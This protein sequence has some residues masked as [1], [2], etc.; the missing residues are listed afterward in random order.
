MAI[1][2]RDAERERLARFVV[3]PSPAMFLV[4]G[5]PGIGKTT[6][7][8]SGAALAERSG[9]RVLALRPGEAE[10]PLAFAGLAGLL[11]DPLLNAT[12]PAIPEPRRRALDAALLR[13]GSPGRG[14]DADPGT[15]GLAVLSVLGLL[16]APA[17]VLVA[18]DDLQWVD[19]ATLRVL[20]F[21]LRRLG[22]TPVSVL[23]ARRGAGSAEPAP[24][25]LAFPEDRRDRLVLG[26]LSVGSIGR[27]VHDRLGLALPRPV[28]ARLQQEAGGNPLLA[29]E[30]ARAIAAQG[31][32]PTPGEPLRVAGDAGALLAGRIARLSPSAGRI[33]VALAALAHPTVELLERALG[34]Q[35]VAEAIPPLVAADL[36]RLDGPDV[37]CAHP[38]VASVAYSTALPARR[39]EV[40][41]RLATVVHD[42]EQ[43]ARHRA[44]A[45]TGP[46]ESVAG[47]LDGAAEHAR[48]RGASDAAA[49]L[50]ELAVRL[51][52]TDDP[53]VVSGRELI[54]AR[55]RLDAGSPAGAREAACRS[56]ELLPRGPERVETLLLLATV[57]H[58]LADL[59]AAREWLRRALDEAGDDRAS[60]VRAH[61]AAAFSAWYDVDSERDH[62][63]AALDLLAGHE[64]DDPE[65]AATA[66]VVL[67]DAD[68][69]GGRGP[70]FELLDRAVGLEASL[71]LPLMARPSTN[72]AIDLGH[73]GRHEESAAAIE[74]VLAIA[75]R[76]GDWT[77]R[78]HLLRCLA[79][80]ELCAG[81]LPAALGHA[82]QAEELAGELGLDDG[83][84]WAVSGQV[85]AAVGRFDE[86]R[87]RCR[88]ALDRARAVGNPWTEIRALGALGFL[89]LT[90]GD[91]AAAAAALAPAS[92]ACGRMGTLEPGW[93][94]VDGDLAEALVLIGRL[95]EAEDLIA[96]FERRA[97]VGRHPW[98]LVVSTRA[99]GL[100]EA[101]RGAHDA[102]IRSLER[103]LAT[104][105]LDQMAVERGRT[106]LALGATLRRANRRRS[107]RAALGES[108]AILA[109]AGC[110]PW[111]ERARLEWAAVSGRVASPSEL[112]GMER[113]VA[114][115]A[116][117]GR[118]NREIATELFLSVR[119]VESHLSSAYRKL[120][121]R[122]RTELGT[123]LAA[124]RP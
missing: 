17:P 55:R 4:E 45:A 118:T 1:L 105:G 25:E 39:R 56:L 88:R 40:H 64:T 37:R 18:L 34:E 51:S 86:A 112:S 108:R 48:R 71:D 62:A 82:E 70:S 75:E 103:S 106:L 83:N 41:E 23:A 102:A 107:A 8:R 59:G 53:S 73:A 60:L 80:V 110:A 20:E 19:E 7:W 116:G 99:R 49:E 66:M 78:P 43:A 69:S 11:T 61:V 93:Y 14:P 22:K 15:V 3:G 115:L 96:A 84:I 109:A 30:L 65:S 87:E 79:W 120:D 47:A 97:S 36:V 90:V 94:R 38:L 57:E 13:D 54:V 81:H 111:A 10:R 68:L 44:L 31:R 46:D 27:L 89:E 92:A 95:D 24:L 67:A 32:L 85:R 6:L 16:A 123:A 117:V 28:V 9:M 121:V 2:G 101:A 100:L 26:G 35:A 76:E 52:P 122:S 124:R 42:A 58:G 5:E 29:L 33:L 50:A 72:R 12:L 63:R 74:I 77:V 91:S 98:S 119:T 113:R 104:D 21:A 114:E